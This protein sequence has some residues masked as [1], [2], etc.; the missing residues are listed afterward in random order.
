MVHLPRYSV[1]NINYTPETESQF[2][3]W[4]FLQPIF[5]H[6]QRC[7]C[8]QVDLIELKIMWNIEKSENVRKKMSKIV[9][10]LG[11]PNKMRMK[12][13]IADEIWNAVPDAEKALEY[14]QP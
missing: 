9:I 10:L 12:Q 7:C 8:C 4:N 6:G 14:G 5:R 13:H 1:V 3:W 2:D 11:Y